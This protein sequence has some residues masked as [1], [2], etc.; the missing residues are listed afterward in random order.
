MDTADRR[1]GLE[2]Q[3]GTLTIASGPGAAAAVRQLIRRDRW[4]TLMLSF[5][6]LIVVAS[7]GYLSLL[8]GVSR[9][10]PRL[11]LGALVALG[12]LA[13]AAGLGMRRPERA[14]G[15]LSDDVRSRAMTAVGPRHPVLDAVRL[16]LALGL[17][18]LVGLGVAGVLL[19]FHGSWHQSGP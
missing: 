19:V 13:A 16:V 12:V 11:L 5:L 10:A 7:G 8:Q 18:I 14:L 3:P 17:V 2:E 15:R 6:I 9:Q 1:G 4:H